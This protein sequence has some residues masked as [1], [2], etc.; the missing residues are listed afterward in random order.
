MTLNS[1]PRIVFSGIIL[2]LSIGVYCFGIWFIGSQSNYVE[3][4]QQEISTMKR[5]IE[6][7]SVLESNVSSSKQLETELQK[8][9]ISRSEIVGFIREI[10]DLSQK[11]GARI[12]IDSID[13]AISDSSTEM[14]VPAQIRISLRGNWVAVTRALMLIENLPYL[15]KVE[16]VSFQ[17]VDALSDSEGSAS[18]KTANSGWKVDLNYTF[19]LIK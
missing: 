3:N 18:S 15:G 12:S 10:E 9:I 4:L 1:F 8:H 17:F 2:V 14:I 11:T 5:E 13:S 7:K 16:G 19:R 6:N